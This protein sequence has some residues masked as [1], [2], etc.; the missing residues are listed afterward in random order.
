MRSGVPSSPFFTRWASQTFSARVRGRASDAL[1]L[2]VGAAFMRSLP[3]NLWSADDG[4]RAGI[5]LVRGPAAAPKKKTWSTHL[6]RLH[7]VR[8]HSIQSHG[9]LA[10]QQRSPV[11]SVDA[12]SGIEFVI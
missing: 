10:E 12:A 11:R 8:R 3:Q 1:E 2:F 5:G 9:V 4:L 6:F 7:R